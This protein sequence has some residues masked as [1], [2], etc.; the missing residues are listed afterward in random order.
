MRSMGTKRTHATVS[1]MKPA[2][3]SAMKDVRSLLRRGA[4]RRCSF[5]TWPHSSRQR[6]ATTARAA[7]GQGTRCSAMQPRMW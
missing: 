5:A 6:R 1:A 3:K 4:R 7:C 2:E